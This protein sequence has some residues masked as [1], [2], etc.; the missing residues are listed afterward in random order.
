MIS[1]DDLAALSG[2][3]KA[4]R[5]AVLQRL[6]DSAPTDVL[7]LL[8]DIEE[9]QTTLAD[10]RNKE[11]HLEDLLRLTL[12]ESEETLVCVFHHL[13][14][15]LYI[16]F[17]KFWGPT[18]RVIIELLNVTKHQKRLLHILLE[19]FKLTNDNIYGNNVRELPEDRPDYVLHRNF[20]LQILAKFTNFVETNNGPFM[21]QLFRFIE[22][23]LMVSPFIEKLSR[24]D[25]T[26]KDDPDSR[27]KPRRPNT[28]ASK[29]K[30]TFITVSR[31]VQSFRNMASVNRQDEFKEFILNLM[32]SRDASMQKAAFNCLTAYDI[33]Y[34]RSYA[35]KILRL[36]DDKKIR[37][38]LSS[39]SI[40]SEDGL[41]NAD[42]RKNL[43]PI[44]HRILFG[45]MI[46]QVG[47]KTSGRDKADKRKSSVMRYIA[48]CTVEEIIDFFK[49]LFDPIFK[50]S[51]SSH[52]K[53]RAIVKSDIDIRSY[54]PLNKLQA[55]LSTLGSYL[56]SVANLKPETLPYL[57]KMISIVSLHVLIPL[58]ETETSSQLD[59]KNV[60]ILKILRRN[61]IEISTNYFKTFPYYRFTQSEIDFIF[62]TLIWPCTEGFIDK[63][64]ATVTPV[65]KLIESLMEN[66]VYHKLAIKRNKLNQD[67][68]LLHHLMTLYGSDKIERPVSL[69]IARMIFNLLK[70]KEE[71]DDDMQVEEPNDE[72]FQLED[73]D[74]KM[75]LYDSNRYNVSGQMTLGLQMMIGY[76][77]VVFDRLK[78]NCLCFL[79]KKDSG[80][81]LESCE[82]QILSA[83]SSY[84]KDS[85]HCLLATKLLLSTIQHQ[86]DANL[87]VGVLKTAQTLMKQV[88]EIDD[89]VII[90][91][92]ANTLSWQRNIEQR[93]ELCKLVEILTGIDSNLKLAGKAVQL[94]N[95]TNEDLVDLP[96]L[97]KWNE[98]FRC[99]FEYLDNL[100][101][102]RINKPSQVQGSLTL[103]LH[104]VGFIVSTLDKY[105]FSVRE[106][107]SI[108]YE[109]LAPKLNM[110]SKE[111]NSKMLK[112]LLADTILEKFLKKGLRDTND[113]IKH[114]YLGILRTLALNCHEQN[115]ILKDCFMFC[116][117]NQDL[118]FWLNIK[119]IQLHNRSKALARLICDENLPKVASKTLSSYF[120]PI[121]GGFLF[122]KNYKSVVSLSD[123]SIKLIGIIC[124]QLNWNTYES[125]LS[126]Y[127]DLLTKSSTTYQ[128][129]N[130]KLITEILK[131][132]N[133]DITACEEAMQYEEEDKKLAKRMLRRCGEIAQ[134]AAEM[135]AD[136]KEGKKLNPSTARM[137]YNAV[138]KKLIPRL[139]SCL[140]EMTRVDFEYD[141]NMADYMPE[142]DE[143]KRIPIAYAIV[144]LINLLPCKYVL[145]RDQLPPLL[146]KLTTFLRSKNE[147]TRKTARATLLRIMTFVGPAYLPDMLRVLKQQLDKGF[148]V[149][150]LNYT[151]HSV[152]N[153]LTL[154]Y[155]DLDSSVEELVGLC[156]QEIFGR[157]AEDKEIAQIL[158]KTSEA[159]KT[160]S[161]DTLLIIA[162]Y[163]SADKLDALFNPLK[164]L[165]KTSTE[166]KVVNKLSICL[167]RVFT[168]LAQ[169]VNFP[170]DRL[171]KFIEDS[172]E[173]SIPSL[174]VR[175]KMES[176]DVVNPGT[177]REDRFLIAKDKSK[178]RVKSKIN[179]KGN[180]HMVVENSLRLLLSI[181]EKN[182][183]AI[184]RKE[185]LQRKLDGLIGLLATC[186]KSSSPRCVMRAL[187]CLYFIAHTKIDLPNFESK[188]NSIVKKIFI[189]LNLYN[190]VGMVHG[191]NYEMIGMC[192]KTLTLLLLKC[193]H[194]QLNGKQ[195][196]ALMSYI[197]QDLH[198]ASRQSTAFK[199]LNSLLQKRCESP[200]LAEIMNKV[201]DLLITSSDSSVRQL[202]I[203][204]WET[205]LLEYQHEPTAMQSHL[206]KFLRQIDYE[207]I[208]GRRSVLKML[209]VIVT[210]MPE[211]ILRNYLELYFHLL[212]QRIVNDDS[213]E[214]REIV[215]HLIGLLM[216]RLPDKQTHVLNKFILPWTIGD[217]AELKML[218]IKL[219]SIFV[220]STP[221][222]FEKN[223]SRL[224]KIL[225]IINE[226]LQEKVA[227]DGIGDDKHSLDDTLN[228]EVDETEVLDENTSPT[229]KQA[230]TLRRVTTLDKL[231]YHSLRL[232]KRLIDKEIVDCVEVRYIDCLKSIWQTIATSKLAH[233]HEPVV[234]TSCSLYMTFITKTSLGQAL[235]VEEPKKSNYIEWNAI[236]I[237]RLLCD[238]FIELLDRYDS[239]NPIYAHVMQGLIILGQMVAQSR[240]TTEFER[241]YVESFENCDVINHVLNLS[242]LPNDGFVAEHL[243]YQVTEA[244]KRC[245]LMWFS[246]K[247]VMQA[248]KEAAVFRLS[249]GYRRDLVLRWIAAIA[250]ELGPTRVSPYVFLYLMTPVRELTDKAKNKSS[251]D[252]PAHGLIPL[253]EDLLKFV[254]GLVGVE[255]FNKIY[256]KVQLHYTRK[257]VER[258]MNAAVSKVRD[259]ARGSK[260]KIAG[261]KK[262]QTLKKRRIAGRK[263]TV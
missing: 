237:V 153:D 89:S 177:L 247:M 127:L 10:Y 243:P 183:L 156:K 211:K 7:K 43:I 6:R 53:L 125:T 176:N 101:E 213:K 133:F 50:F 54:V 252:S 67:E 111:Q 238:K 207:Y 206:T 214:I 30:E 190:G 216:Q 179:E 241:K 244:R 110:I 228:K 175:Q 263:A 84:L 107:C 38:E 71:D 148:Y 180:L 256:A 224:L 159:K 196:R 165:V 9:V 48:G 182:K 173:E 51:D 137:V 187:K 46:G 116:S 4:D 185:T 44:I 62:E 12:N 171:I 8:V 242:D 146:L 34:I 66:D 184:K 209:Q 39:F 74:S 90:D 168:G 235:Q 55:M 174:K 240:A 100:D 254:K 203:K 45:R 253:A 22:S 221:K 49:L 245:D 155:G 220:E 23:E 120:M 132:F 75:P 200:E 197:E 186:L 41:I 88:T 70:L 20:I 164:E 195:V 138:T 32:T 102:E 130:I 103:L 169:N 91:F 3:C 193:E 42:H 181:F 222:L 1:K 199:A 233:W 248:R 231:V 112:D 94:M 27:R 259:Q 249:Q 225:T 37:S 223:P 93:K 208:D 80:Y 212:A 31:I 172:I 47:K 149:H 69:C 81:R 40:D 56:E 105:E 170:L 229:E 157:P 61:C 204:I 139:N 58:E 201:A 29:S 210:K 73:I 215:G 255:A 25:L 162:T 106:N 226:S 189:L 178:N 151:V 86:K 144:Q 2:P 19:E 163:I 239:T 85:S 63:N 250:Q 205:Y 16:N 82:L 262:K 202:S 95:A 236:R 141:K 108:F 68:Y 161:Y 166:P 152:L 124:R 134:Q 218:G 72:I 260:R 92:I 191:D 18:V 147:P 17:E 246:I 121:A 77:P 113:S 126:Y 13:L 198:D 60:K 145:F 257:R 217:N 52:D 76:I 143:I 64:Y 119:H 26:A 167:Q 99:A 98:G 78:K 15:T 158:A 188:C 35:D 24:Q 251:N 136:S 117:A 135:N 140:N 33:D 115:A 114:A 154:N 192:F 230:S 234:L 150:V 123:N 122:N 118:D 104:Q 83:L 87:I 28:S 194:V 5:L 131:N 59:M 36:L 97:A 258:K 57:L 142:K 129:T 96:D 128:R 79:E 65:L 219:I 261:N 11:R 160:K 21:E 227:K 232:F 14:G 109:K